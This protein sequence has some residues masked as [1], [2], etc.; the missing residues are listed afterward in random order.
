MLKRLQ[1]EEEEYPHTRGFCMNVKGKGS[2]EKRFE[3]H[4]N[5]GDQNREVAKTH[6]TEGKARDETGTLS[7]EP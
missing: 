7:A 6:G 2:P 1:V 3:D 5:K 4:E